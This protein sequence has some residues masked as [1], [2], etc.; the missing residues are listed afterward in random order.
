VSALISEEG[1]RGTVL[2]LVRLVETAGAIIILAGAV[3]GFVRFLLA[4]ALPR[5]PA[6][7][8]ATRGLAPGP[9]DGD[10]FGMSYWDRLQ[11]LFAGPA[12]LRFFIPPLVALL[13]GLRDARKDA[14]LGRGPYLFTLIAHRGR[15]SR[16]R[17]GL[18]S[19]GKLL[20]VAVALDLVAQV[21]TVGNALLWA[22][23]VTGTLLIALPYSAARGL[24]NRA[25]R[26]WRRRH[27]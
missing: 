2:L 9:G 4:A 19:F 24:G 5:E 26:V 8:N 18:E 6:L 25:L 20:L 14:D 15:W 13:L 21:L 1:L 10:R 7:F 16:L 27:A 12:H 3:T 22:A 11:D 17:E 23:L